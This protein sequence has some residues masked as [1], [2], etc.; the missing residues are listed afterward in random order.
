MGNRLCDL[1]RTAAGVASTVGAMFPVGLVNPG[2]RIGIS[3]IVFTII[4]SNIEILNMI[5]H[6]IQFMLNLLTGSVFGGRSIQQPVFD[7]IIAE[8]D[9]TINWYR[10]L[11]DG[12]ADLFDGIHR[13]AGAIFRTFDSI[14]VI[15]RNLL[16]DAAIEMLSLMFKVFGG[17]V[18]MFT[19]GSLYTEFFNDLWRLITK[20]IEMLL[21]NA[22]KLLDAILNML[23][24]VGQFIRDMSSE[25]C[26]ALQ[27]TLCTLTAG[28]LCDLGCVGIGPASSSPIADA[29]A[30]VG[31]FFDSIFGHRLHA[32]LHSLPRILHDELEWDG[33]SDCDLYVHAYKDYNFTDLRPIERVQLLQCVEQRALAVEMEKQLEMPI[34][35]DIV[36]NWKRKWIMAYHL[37]QSG[38]IYTKY[39]VNELSP[40]EM[41]A[42]MKKAGVD[43]D[44]Y[45]P[46]W[47]RVRLS[48]KS[49]TTLAHLDGFIH[50]LFHNFDEDIKTTDSAFGNM[51]RIYSHTS[52]AAKD[53]YNTTSSIDLNFQI[54]QATKVVL[55]TN[56]TWPQIPQHI[57]TSYRN[58]GRVTVKASKT[59]NPH[60]LKA[61]RIILKAAGMNTDITPC[62]DQLDSNVCVNCLVIDNLLNVALNEGKR[63]AGYYENTFVPV[64]L[65]SFIDYFN[66][67]DND[68]RAKAWR[69]D[70]GML[71]D[72]AATAAGNKIN[73]GLNQA[74]ESINNFAEE[75]YQAAAKG[76][77]LQGKNH[78]S[79]NITTPI[80]VWKRANK[81]WAY[82]FKNFKTRDGSSFITVLEKFLTTTDDSF[83]PF[84]AH[85]A[86]WFVT[87]PFAGTCSMEVIYC[88]SPGYET[89]EKRLDRIGDAFLYMVY[90]L[91]SIFLL[92]WFTGFPILSVVSPYVLFVLPF[93]YVLTV[94]NWIYPCFPNIP[95]C[96]ADDVFA[97]LND[98]LFPSCW[99]E[100]FPGLANS[101]ELENCFLCSVQTTYKECDVEIED[102][103]NLG[104]F[105]A[106]LTFIRKSSPK[107]LVFLYNTIPTLWLFR[108]IKSLDPIFQKAIYEIPLTQIET[109]CYGLRIGDIIIVV[110]I[111]YVMSTILQFTAPV[112]IRGM[113]SAFKIFLQVVG[114]FY[115][116]AVSVE[117]STVSGNKNTYQEGL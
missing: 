57:K 78:M 67:E 32:S 15:L 90:F 45:L 11:I 68:A 28:G 100:G 48:L 37:F 50:K 98:R 49:F 104:V 87:Y 35:H 39:S 71:M 75:Q 19:S 55:S 7:F 13:G 74:G 107:T 6:A 27:G 88:N 2:V 103:K 72:Q 61:R 33:T 23:G 65:P 8:I 80:T 108:R 106:P 52:R 34:P 20:L 21:V 16:T 63:M 79:F 62:E 91:L 64:I 84:F 43:L 31:G 14:I 22:G 5:N 101:C 77:K 17:I 105:W 47:N 59:K 114:L 12:F 92:D 41:V 94:Y 51:Y 60:K 99:C 113:Q 36:Y 83:V 56:V 10:G 97:F 42:E 40:K 4:D 69:E 26:G 112:A 81:D 73:S 111:G 38:M 76:Y 117:L 70:M 66:N 95:N 29:G 96:L 85:S 54:A 102:L 89:T 44:L 9:I 116:M 30:A 93:I 58:M 24:P 110:V 86:S 115:S 53:I 46:F 82:L 109:D 25:I 1:Q 3:K 18:E